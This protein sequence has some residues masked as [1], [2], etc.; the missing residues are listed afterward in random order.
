[1]Q[2]GAGRCSVERSVQSVGALPPK[3]GRW[4]AGRARQKPASWNACSSSAPRD[5][6]YAA[7]TAAASTCMDGFRAQ[8]LLQ[9]TAPLALEK[10]AGRLRA[11]AGPMRKNATRKQTQKRGDACSTRLHTPAAQRAVKRASIPL[12]GVVMQ[13]T[14]HAATI[15]ASH[16]L[17]G[18]PMRLRC[19]ASPRIL[20]AAAKSAS[21]MSCAAL[22]QPI[23]RRMWVNSRRAS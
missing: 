3:P 5:G 19:R 16:F 10:A 7:T 12:F 23:V 22:C 20:Q 2:A 18:R 8:E 1:M 11:G 17:G 6:R 4:S 15:S 21:H 14:P 9:F 13:P